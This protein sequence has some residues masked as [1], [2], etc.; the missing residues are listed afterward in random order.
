MELDQFQHADMNDREMFAMLVSVA[1]TNKNMDF[2]FI[3]C[4]EHRKVVKIYIKG[5]KKVV[6]FFKN[7]SKLADK[8][9]KLAMQDPQID[10]SVIMAAK[11]FRH[12]KNYYIKELKIAKDMLSEYREYVCSG[13]LIDTF[14]LPRWRPDEECVDYRT[15][16]G[17]FMFKK[18]N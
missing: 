3:R 13:H 16:P 9:A 17:V 14:I 5:V 4:L 7:I 18:P 8:A 6:K 11:E 1:L 15:L 12:C 2:E 10:L